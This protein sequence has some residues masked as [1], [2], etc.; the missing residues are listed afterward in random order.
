ML[1]CDFSFIPDT[2]RQ[3]S[4]YKFKIKKAEQE[5]TNLEGNVSR[6]PALV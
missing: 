6:L 3:I 4:D 2:Q 5:I 1:F